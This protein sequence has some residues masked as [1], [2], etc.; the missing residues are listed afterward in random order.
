MPGIVARSD[1]QV[2]VNY[3]LQ[4]EKGSLRM[5]DL[6]TLMMRRSPKRLHPDRLPGPAAIADE[7][8]AEQ[9]PGV[10]GP[11]APLR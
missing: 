3:L 6:R 10:D 11:M 4:S 8:A 5:I 2:K 9:R 1:R 7:V